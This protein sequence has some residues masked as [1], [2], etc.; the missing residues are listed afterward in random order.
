M[1]KPEPVG[2]KGRGQAYVEK[3]FR[4]KIARAGRRVPFLKEVITLHDFMR[5]PG[6]P[7]YKKAVAIGALVYFIVPWD[8]IIDYSPL[9]GYLDDAG[10]IAAAT[11]YLRKELK[12]YLAKLGAPS[13]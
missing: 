9:I 12:S 13:A 1:E 8:V 6:V 5:D 7:R 11:G 3:G 4:P 10:V 2:K